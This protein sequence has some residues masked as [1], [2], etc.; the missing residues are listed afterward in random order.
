MPP[1]R[2]AMIQALAQAVVPLLRK[3]GYTGSFPHFRRLSSAKTDLLTFQF[4]RSGGAFLIELAEGPA[5][6]FTT[7][8]GSSVPVDKLRTWDLSP[9]DRARLLPSGQP[10]DVWY[11]FNREAAPAA[12]ASDVMQD[13]PVVEAWFAGAKPHPRIH[14][15]PPSGLPNGRP[16]PTRRLIQ[17]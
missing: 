14:G 3:R 6:D 17:E 11:H 9:F 13:L 7:P 2:K 10:L 5:T 16:K 12:V 8:S 15:Y 1:D 4:A